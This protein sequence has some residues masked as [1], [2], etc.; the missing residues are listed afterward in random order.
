MSPTAQAQALSPPAEPASRPAAEQ[1]ASGQAERSEREN[2][3]LEKRLLRLAGQ[4]EAREERAQPV[5]EGE[6][7]E[8][9]LV[10][11][12]VHDGHVGRVALAHVLANG[13]LVQGVL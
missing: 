2:H 12:G 11:V 1:P 13:G 4:A 6:A 10:H 5:V 9:E 7:R 8:V 3:K